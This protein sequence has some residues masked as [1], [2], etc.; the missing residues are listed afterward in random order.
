MKFGDFISLLSN[1]VIIDVEI[2]DGIH[3]RPV[4]KDT[5]YSLAMNED[6][7]FTSLFDHKVRFVNSYVV[8]N[9]YTKQ[10]EPVIGITLEK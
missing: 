10:C 1:M 4:L 2:K 7:T 9:T 6:E 3:Y 5:I 8:W